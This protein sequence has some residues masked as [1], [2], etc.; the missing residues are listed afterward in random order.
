MIFILFINVAIL[1]IFTLAEF[2][3]LG[4][5]YSN[6]ILWAIIFSFM[7]AAIILSIVVM[8]SLMTNNVLSV[9]FSI[10]VFIVS[11]SMT[12]VLKIERVSCFYKY[13]IKISMIILPDL[14]VL[15]I[16]NYVIYESSLSS[17]YLLKSSAYGAIYL[18]VILLIS[19]FLF[20]KKDIT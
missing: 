17:S 20:S 13:I 14:E 7:E 9:I 16:K 15:N 10:I 1:S 18:M 3:I 4:G 2:F 8:F 6:L 5:G 19:I 12:E 11:H